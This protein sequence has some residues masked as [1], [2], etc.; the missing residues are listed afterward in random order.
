APPSLQNIFKELKRDLNIDIPDHG[1]LQSWAE[2]G[3]LLLNTSL[4]VQ[5]GSAGSH[6][7]K[8]W[9]PFTDKVIEVVNARPGNLVFLLWGSH[10]PPGAAA[11][12]S[13]AAVGLPRLP[14]QR[15]LRPRQ[16][17]PQAVRPH[18]DR[19]AT[20]S[21]PGVAHCRPAVSSRR[22]PRLSCRR[23]RW[24]ASALASSW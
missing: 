6:A 12:A 23:W 13:I 20:A 2:Q 11:G 1:Y 8:G 5:Q 4:T 3:V 22:L 9:Q 7:D 21:S 15:P 16:P 19:L 18:S 10:A 14:R 17:V 24:E